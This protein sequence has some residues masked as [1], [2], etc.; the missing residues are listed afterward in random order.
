MMQLCVFFFN[1][2]FNSGVLPACWLEGVIRTIYKNKGDSK[3]L[4]NYRP[5]TFLSCFGK[6]FTSILNP[7]LNKFLDA[8]NILEV[9]QSGFCTDYS[10]MDHMFC[11]ACINRNCKNPEIVLFFY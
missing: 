8:H 7:R 3:S 5:I 9:N 6:L 11:I 2:T 10:T 4:D 1:L